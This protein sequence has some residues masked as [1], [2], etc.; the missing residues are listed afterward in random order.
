MMQEPGV[1]LITGNMAAGKS[2]VAQAL[3]ERLP[4]SVQLRGDTFRRMIVSGQAAMTATLSEEAE[5]QLWLRYRLAAATAKIYLQAGFTVIY[6]DIII[7]P[8]LT[9]VV[10]MYAHHP[11]SVI[12]LCPRVEV[13]AAREAARAKTGYSDEAAIHTFDR[14][15]RD[16]TPRT[17]YWLDSSDLTIVETVDNILRNL[18]PVSVAPVSPPTK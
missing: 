6:Q 18:S 5:R 17:G 12:V 8:V 3:A 4:K 1:I 15:L 14:V 7:G 11:L 10:A 9:K 2:S 16:E 13:V